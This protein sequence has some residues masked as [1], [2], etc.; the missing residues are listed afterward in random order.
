[1]AVDDA[2]PATQPEPDTAERTAWGRHLQAPLRQFLRTETGSA[3]VL[4]G[5]TIAALVWT[6]VDAGSYDSLSGTQI[7]LRLGG[8]AVSQ[9]PHGYPHAQLAAEAA[10]AAA[11]QGAFWEMHDVLLRNQDALR[12]GDLIR[13]AA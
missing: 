11:A 4:L 10:E 1:M 9:D 2:T 3:A 6:N 8:F 13:Y 12:P 7:S 5:A